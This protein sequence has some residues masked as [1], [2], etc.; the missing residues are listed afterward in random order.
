MLR[1]ERTF[2][3]ERRVKNESLN[4]ELAKCFQG[5]A[6]VQWERGRVVGLR[7]DSYGEQRVEGLTGHCNNLGFSSE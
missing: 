2:W 7:S 5:I 4:W 1:P 6:R 3:V